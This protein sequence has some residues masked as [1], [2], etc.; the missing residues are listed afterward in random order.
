MKRSIVFL[1]TLFFLAGYLPAIAQDAA[2]EA[3]NVTEAR[4]LAPDGADAEPAG[5]PEAA[6]EEGTAGAGLEPDQEAPEG[7]YIM[8]RDTSGTNGKKVAVPVVLK[9]DK[10][11][12]GIIFAVEFDTTQLQIDTTAKGADA[13]AL[14]MIVQNPDTAN[15]R[16]SMFVSL[17]DTTLDNLIVPAEEKE[18][19]VIT[20]TIAEDASEQI[21]VSLTNVSL[22]DEAAGEI[23][24]TVVSGTI[25]A[26]AVIPGDANGDG[27]VNIFDLLGLLQ[28]LSGSAEPAHG[29]DANED[30]VVNIFD[31]LALL[32]LLTG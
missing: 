16:G 30:G 29:S 18:I 23:E 27:N 32:S 15:V 1:V 12:A 2:A 24:V 19:F 3:G 11:M 7:N 26:A 20:F 6:G 13:A 31:L 5:D 4:G 9:I 14:M 10:N 25:T 22:S 17:I 28:V 21:M 8:A